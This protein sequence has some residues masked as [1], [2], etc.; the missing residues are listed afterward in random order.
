M[1][2]KLDMKHNE[3][4]KARRNLL[5]TASVLALVAL[6]LPNAA[7]AACSTPSGNAG[8]IIYNGTY[9]VLQ[10]CNGTN[11]INTGSLNA[12]GGA[13]INGDFCSS[14]GSLISCTIPS[15]G[16]GS[17]VLSAS[18][19]ITGTLAGASSS[20]SGTVAGNSSTWTGSVAIGTTTTSGALNVAGTVTA[21]GF[22][23]S[24]S[25]LTGIGISSL[26]GI[27]GTPNSTNYLRGDGTWAT[28]SNTVS[29]T[30]T[31]NN[32]AMWTS[33]TAIGTSSLY[34]S[35][36][37]IGIGTTSPIYP[38]SVNSSSAING[39]VANFS[40]PANA[41]NWGYINVA[42]GSLRATYGIDP[43]GNAHVFGGPGSGV[44]LWANGNQAMIIGTSGNVGIGTTSPST[45][46]Q[47][48]GTVTSTG[49]QV[50]G[51]ATATTFSGS[52]TGSGAG[53]TGIGTSNM[54][55]VTGTASNTT[56][57]RG[58]GTW[59]TLASGGAATGAGTNNYTA[60]WT[61]TN[62]LGTGILYD[63]G[64]N[65]GIGLTSPAY[66]LHLYSAAGP[67]VFLQ[68]AGKT[69]AQIA[70][71]GNTLFLTN[72][73]AGDIGISAGA[74]GNVVMNAGG[75]ER[76][77]VTSAGNVGINTANPGANL[78]VNGTTAFTLG[79]DYS[80]VGTQTDVSFGS[81]T[82]VRYTG[83]SAGTF[84]G[85][86]AGTNGQILT[87]H[88]ASASTLTLANQS[89]T[90]TTAAN[91][92]IT[93]L[94]SDLVMQGNTSAVL[95]Y[96]ATATRW[97]VVANSGGAT[98]AGTTGQVQY[99]SGSNTL[100]ASSNLTYTPAN[101]A[102][103]VG[104]GAATPSATTGTVASFAMNVIPQA[105]SITASGSSGGVVTNSATTNQM[106][107]YSGAS[108]VSGTPNM[109][110]SG[111]NIAIGT[112]TATT[113]LQV[114]GTVTASAFAGNGATLTG[115]GTSSLGGITGTPT[116]TTFLTGN[117]AWTALTTA[118]F[119]TLSSANIWVGNG[120]NVAAPVA[121]SGDITLSNTGVTAVSKIAGTTVSG[122]TGSGNVVF[123]ASPTFSGTITGGTFSGTHTGN[124]SGLTSI[125]VSA[126]SGITGT[127]NSTNFLR[128][129]GTW[130]AP[131]GSITGSG[132][133]NYVARW[134]GSGTLGTGTLYDNGSAVGI[135]NASPVTAL[136]VQGTG[137]TTPS[138]TANAGTL[139]INNG[140]D[141]EMQIGQVNSGGAGVFM[142][143]KR[144]SNDGTNWGIYLNPLG[145]NV[146]IGKTSPAST[147]DVNGTITAPTLNI[148]AYTQL[149]GN[150]INMQAGS[151]QGEFGVNYS[152]TANVAFN[153]Y[154]GSGTSKIYL[155]P[156]GNT[157][158]NGGNV[159]IGN[160]GP[161]VKLDVSGDI[162]V[163][164]NYFYLAGAGDTNHAIHNTSGDGEQFRFWNFLDL[165]QANGGASRIYV[166]G[167]GNI[168]IHNTSP[169]Y[170]LDVSGDINSSGTIYEH[171]T[172]I[173]G[174]AGR[175]YFVDAEKS[176]GG[177]LRVGAAWGMYGIYSNSGS[178]VVG[179][180]NGVI[181]L[182]GDS[183][184]NNYYHNSDRRLKD[185]IKPSKGLDV[186]EKINGVTFNWKKDGK[187][188]AGVIAQ[189]VQAV[190]PEAVSE[191]KDKTLAVSYD[192]LFAPVIEAIKEL[193]ALF[194]TD[195]AAIAKLQTQNDEQAAAIKELRK[196]FDDYRAKHP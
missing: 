187:P 114:A 19:T 133:A 145:G 142:Q 146:G 65:V 158:F 57:L 71:D 70:S 53:L 113:A 191:T 7:K 119:P 139:T 188:S 117:G 10:Y 116:S 192:A 161:G 73:D 103:V 67:S 169:G 28:I 92:I 143:S 79:T 32:I 4:S 178:V 104:T 194:D 140:G 105:V 2:R 20:W 152:G 195:H 12:S 153:L 190:M 66:N 110:V 165:Y 68:K 182:Q 45:A 29:G 52:Y 121:V 175:N 173:Q 87:L 130:A 97:R 111:S 164:R 125:G 15:T 109:Y 123:S 101:G 131:S 174:T 122:T 8:D 120:S 193:K 35:G 27:T 34:Q 148:G 88:N 78:T 55:G 126:L 51:T 60:R 132:T 176:D 49:L 54:S 154:N 85:I 127:A 89:A 13:L 3:P 108:A 31:A 44:T 134:T 167:S 84:Y 39:P 16:T 83:A 171:G 18:P 180:A 100:A 144:V 61:G 137:A 56:Y 74:S 160:S 46:L 37:N 41:G 58:D 30:G 189:D 128:G 9:N 150:Q 81:T 50:N 25:S 80:T 155:N 163:E 47:V 129:D 106:A 77:R 40:M 14:N 23:G 1:I 181:V 21:T 94:G 43:N 166:N 196:E 17:V 6:S 22:S 141:L 159:G 151:G 69:G 184:A 156:N 177:G 63:N 48:N 42:Q 90:D 186:V 95:Q 118:A 170:T 38:L 185:N 72:F 64:T 11:W 82:A 112:T 124:G 115:I 62:T 86:V 91:R 107:F 59:T 24:G 26:T 162:S 76:M 33:S 136:T 183:Y 36:S 138:L 96:D 149:S 75:S 99:N 102:L 172:T 147:L 179:A 157:Y 168:G 98:P 135:G 93:G 5:F